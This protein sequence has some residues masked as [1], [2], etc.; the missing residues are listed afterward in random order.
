MTY[1]R[2]SLSKHSGGTRCNTS[3]N[4][5]PVL[6]IIIPLHGRLCIDAATASPPT[7]TPASSARPFCPVLDDVRQLEIHMQIAEGVR[8]GACHARTSLQL[9][10]KGP[11]QHRGQQSPEF[12]CRFSSW[13]S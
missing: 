13:I 2:T 5:P 4:V 3:Q 7:A 6:T 1:F 12:G 8:R 10:A 9:G 11:L